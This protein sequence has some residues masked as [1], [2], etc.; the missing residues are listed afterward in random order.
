MDFEV[1]ADS[2]RDGVYVVTVTAT[3]PSNKEQ[4]I[5]FN[6]KITDVNET[7]E[8]TLG[9]KDGVG[10]TE[11]FSSGFTHPEPVVS[12]N[13]ESGDT[14][15]SLSITLIG[16]DPEKENTNNDNDTL[17]WTLAGT[18]ADDFEIDDGVL[19]FK[20]VPDFEAPTDSGRNNVYEV[21]VQATSAT[22]NMA[23][24]RVRITVENVGEK[25]AITLS[26]IQPEER[27]R[28]TAS[29]ADPDKARSI[30]WQWYREVSSGA[31]LPI[32]NCTDTR[33][34]A[35]LISG[36]T[37]ASYIPREYTAVNTDVGQLLTVEAS[38]L[39]G[40]G[41]ETKKRINLRLRTT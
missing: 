3:D 12:T 26:H 19:T 18:D 20:S 7:P 11:T 28:L 33:A 4:S 21:T 16:D 25:G 34:T 40:A 37:S 5:T 14:S 23:S 27:F 38:Y 17:T 10:D 36:A 6:I 24:K 15:P 2:N 9:V 13:R 31:D 35:C 1:Q 30:R 39:D 32:D 41:S 8:L 22:G 29:L